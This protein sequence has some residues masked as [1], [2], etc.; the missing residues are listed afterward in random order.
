[1]VTKSDIEIMR[2]TDSAFYRA[3]R[4]NLRDDAA[5]LDEL[6]RKYDT[7]RE[8]CE[9]LIKRVGYDRARCVIASLVNANGWDGRI[10]TLTLQWANDV[11]TSLDE[12]ACAEIYLNTTMHRC[13][14][15]QIG[16][17]MAMMSRGEYAAKGE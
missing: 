8:T 14:L 11:P 16:R 4:R 7:P 10:G 2:K 13:H 3:L 5:L 17:T 6:Q 15:D 9:Q 12:D 1:M